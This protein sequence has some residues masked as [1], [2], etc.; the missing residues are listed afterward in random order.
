MAMKTITV[1]FGVLGID[2]ADKGIMLRPFIVN[3]IFFT[4]CK[5]ERVSSDNGFTGIR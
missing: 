2:A 1:A 3:V 5:C 4:E